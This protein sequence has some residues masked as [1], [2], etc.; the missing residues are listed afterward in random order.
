MLIVQKFGGS[1]L[2][3]ISG[4]RRAADIILS[5]VN[6]SDRVVAV[7]S[8]MG[9]ATD[10]LTEL[11][12]RISDRPPDRELDAL[13]S[14]GEMQSAALLSIMLNSLGQPAR[15]F[16][17]PQAGISTDDKHCEANIVSIHPDSIK[18]TLDRRV[19]AIVA[20]FQG[21]CPD[22][23]ICTLGRGGSDTSA[24]A[25]AA[26]LNAQRCEIYKD[27]DGI[28]TADPLLAK[29]AR[30]LSHID[31]RDMHALTAN[32]SQVLHSRSVYTAMKAG[33][34][35]LI[36]NSF[37]KGDGT[38]VCELSEEERP[39]FAGITRRKA[40]SSLSLAGKGANSES[41]E[42]LCGILKAENIPILSKK[43]GTGF[44][45]VYT[46][47]DRLEQALQVAHTEF[48]S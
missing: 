41:L 43:L 30:L 2:A 39:A 24:V 26:A 6:R 37:K 12:H 45:T 25:L 27:V 31:Y 22:G 1:S 19:V 17:G 28:Y 11:A 40:D 3:D 14:T 47:P 9:D 38:A 4:L 20:G 5:A 7:V 48:L 13:L 36:L 46:E 33:L 35:M 23:S 15:S 8:A 10:S 18:R 29:D 32:G 21:S 16:S 42:R 34:P 44:I